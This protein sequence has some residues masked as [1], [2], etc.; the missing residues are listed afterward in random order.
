[1]QADQREALDDPRPMIG[2]MA[3]AYPNPLGSPLDN[4]GEEDATRGQD[5][6]AVAAA[7]AAIEAAA[8]A[9]ELVIDALMAVEAETVGPEVRFVG[10]PRATNFPP[11][12]P[13]G[14]AWR[15]ADGLRVVE[16]FLPKGVVKRGWLKKHTRELPGSLVYFAQ[17]DVS[18]SGEMWACTEDG[19]VGDLRRVVAGLAARDVKVREGKGAAG[20]RVLGVG[21]AG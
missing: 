14:G 1:M 19:I 9:T 5:S 15:G 10:M 18:V 21:I 17:V 13:D 12:K 20:S 2:V 4:S 7:T 11:R 3:H 8:A 6:E 16:G